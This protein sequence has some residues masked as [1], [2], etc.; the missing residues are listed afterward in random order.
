MI[1]TPDAVPYLIAPERGFAAS[2]RLL[3]ADY[4]GTLVHDG[5]APYDRFAHASHQTCPAH[6]LRRCHEML[7]AATRGAVVFPPQGQGDPGPGV[8]GPRSA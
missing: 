2:A 4:A 6:L 3:G 1:A 5:W 8:G 7:E